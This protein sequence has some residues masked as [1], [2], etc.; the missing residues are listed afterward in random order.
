[1]SLWNKDENG[2]SKLK[3]NPN[4]RKIK[5]VDVSELEV[6]KYNNMIIDPNY[7]K[8]EVNWTMFNAFQQ[9][10]LYF[11]N[12]KDAESNTLVK[13]NDLK[14]MIT[15]LDGGVIYLHD[16]MVDSVLKTIETQLV[17]GIKTPSLHYEQWSYDTSRLFI[18]LN[19]PTRDLDFQWLKLF[20]KKL[21]QE[22]KSHYN[23]SQIPP[24]HISKREDIGPKLSGCSIHI[25][26]HLESAIYD[27]IQFLKSFEKGT[28]KGTIVDMK[29]VD[30]KFDN[31]YAKS[32]KRCVKKLMLF[33]RQAPERYSTLDWKE[34]PRYV[35]KNVF[36]P[37]AYFKMNELERTLNVNFNI[38]D[39]NIWVEK[40]DVLGTFKLP[41]DRDYVNDK[42]LKVISDFDLD[43]IKFIVE[44]EFGDVKVTC[45]KYTNRGTEY[46]G[47]CSGPLC[48]FENDEKMFNE[49]NQVNAAYGSSHHPYIII[50][51][52][53][54]TFSC[55]HIF[56]KG[57]KIHKALDSKIK[58][59]LFPPKSYLKIFGDEY[60]WVEEKEKG[61]KNPIEEEMLS[62]K[63]ACL[64]QSFPGTGKSTAVMNFLQSHSERYERILAI[65]NGRSQVQTTV[66]LLKKALPD[67][68]VRAYN[69]K[70]IIL[71]HCEVLVIE[72]ESLHRLIDCELFDLYCWMRLDQH[73]IVQQI[74]LQIIVI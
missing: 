7:V 73:F 52:S 49:A 51:N 15:C 59:I 74:R 66:N 2:N 62:G 48:I 27:S 26:I 29:E 16:G 28:K 23:L 34:Y 39:H 8:H 35:K 1:M 13:E 18:E 56:C 42:N 69:E 71:K 41:R 6:L 63:R 40:E 25:V 21:I 55:S 9:S 19:A 46:V 31:Y 37:F 11:K 70:N 32:H 67:R 33:S 3:C 65:S 4:K 10:K 24:I 64:L 50:S 61:R 43:V 58:E 47:Y 44:E 22:L 30:I 53:T 38:R 17:P 12:K 54:M 72:Y 20:V 57:Q 45:I 5:T 60:L 68:D 36:E 14:L